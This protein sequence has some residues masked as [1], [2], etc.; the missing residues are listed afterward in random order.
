V[1]VFVWSFLAKTVGPG[2]LIFS[3]GFVVFT[4]ICGYLGGA[5]LVPALA[6]A[7]LSLH[8]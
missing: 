7:V 6:R 3:I 1:P 5:M 2:V 4:V 8:R